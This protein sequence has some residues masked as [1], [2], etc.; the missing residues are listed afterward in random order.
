MTIT[1][2]ARIGLV[3]GV[4]FNDV[5]ALDHMTDL[6]DGY[7]AL[8]HALDC[9]EPKGQGRER[10]GHERQFPGCQCTLIATWRF[11]FVSVARKTWP[12]RL[13]QSKQ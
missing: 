10:V 8:E 7:P 12:C 9:V 4:I 11:R 3:V 13:R 6:V 2:L 1:Q 5:A